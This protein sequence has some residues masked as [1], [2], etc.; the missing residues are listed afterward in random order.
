[1]RVVSGSTSNHIVLVDTQSV[2]SELTGKDA[3]ILLNDMGITLNRNAIPFDTR[4]PFVTSGIRMGT[5]AVTTCG[6]KEEQLTEVGQLISNI[7]K[8]RDDELA[9]VSLKDQVS[10]LAVSY[11]PYG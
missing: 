10:D 7:L 8:N 6:M 3:G 5:P 2:D 4:S 1:M 9:L 11:Q